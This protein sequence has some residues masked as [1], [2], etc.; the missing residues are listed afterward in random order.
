MFKSKNHISSTEERKNTHEINL[1]QIVEALVKLK[2]KGA[3]VETNGDYKSLLLYLK[4]NKVISN[5]E[6]I[7]TLNEK[8]IS[9]SIEKTLNSHSPSVKN[10]SNFQFNNQNQKSWLKEKSTHIFNEMHNLYNG[11]VHIEGSYSDLLVNHHTQ[12]PFTEKLYSTIELKKLMLISIQ[13]KIR[14]DLISSTL[15]SEERLVDDSDFQFAFSVKKKPQIKQPQK[16][17]FATKVLLNR[18]ELNSKFRDQEENTKNISKELHKYWDNR[19]KEEANELELRKQQRLDALRANNEEDYYRLLQQD[20][21]QQRLIELLRQTDECLKSLGAQLVQSRSGNED[22][23]S[24]ISV[25]PQS[26]TESDSMLSK[27]NIYSKFFQ[28]QSSYYKIAHR[29]RERVDKQPSSLKCGALKP[30]QLKG[31]QWMVSLY[32]NKLNGILADEMGLGKTIQTIALVT[33]LQEYKNNNGPHLIIVPLGTLQNWKNEF[34]NWAPHLKVVVYTGQSE[35]RKKLNKKYLRSGNFNVVLTQYEY[36]TRDHRI[37]KKPKWSYIIMDEGHRI[38]NS[39]CKLVLTLEKFYRSNFRLLLTG[40]PLQNDLKELWS[41]LNF[42]LPNVFD[43]VDSFENWFNSPFDSK[44]KRVMNEEEVLLVVTR[45][46]QVLRPF[47]LRRVKDDVLDQ[48]PEKVEHILYCDISS[49]QKKMYTQLANNCRILVNSEGVVK[50][51]SLNNSVMQLRKVANHPYLFFN[52]YTIDENFIRSSG[53]FALLDDI[54]YKLSSTGH[55]ILLFS[56]M[57]QTLDLLEELC[58]YR[59]FQY[60][61]LDGNVKAAER[62]PLLDEFNKKNSPYFIFLLSTRAGGLGLNL[63]TADTVILFDSDWNPQQD[64]QAMARAHRIGQ[65]KSVRVFTFCT[66]TPVEERILARAK[67]K[68]ATEMQVIGAGKFNE[69]STYRERQTLLQQLIQQKSDFKLDKVPNQFQFNRLIARGDEEAKLFDQMDIERENLRK[70]YFEKLGVKEPRPPLMIEEELPDWLRLSDDAM[71][72]IVKTEVREVRERSKKVNYSE[73]IDDF[74]DEIV[75]DYKRSRD[76]DEDENFTTIKKPKKKMRTL[77]PLQN[78]MIQVLDLI[79][80]LQ[81]EDGY[82]ISELFLELPSR[83]DFEDYYKII[84]N[85]ISLAE[86]REKIENGSYQTW[87]QME[88]DFELL[89]SNCKTFNIPESEICLYAQALLENYRELSLNYMDD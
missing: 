27:Q 25:D 49:M 22:E 88:Q 30:Y 68:R 57:T 89:V 63:Q 38:K 50:S 78:D 34:Q 10:F 2:N 87:S 12:V 58:Q 33:Y 62:G 8:K 14:Q 53:K 3:T 32:N 65:T 45:L 29:T 83:N 15:P 39:K 79:S 11:N 81:E 31:L 64:L 35:E 26:I 75:E 67:E 60:L 7:E 21:N 28:N 80:E 55:R 51:R 43:S 52:E 9:N 82:Q 66:I 85:P 72:E 16:V 74:D 70:E 23:F 24:D 48:L 19:R 84:K 86:I 73:E 6:Q 4:N 56:Q 41:L 69:S 5:L 18:Q 54:M 40:T 1:H 37:L 36:I 61:R 47:L 42:L 44:N 13:K 76:E 71:N 77:S 59:Q 20:E 17:S 46:H